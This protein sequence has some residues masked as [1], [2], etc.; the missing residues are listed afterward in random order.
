MALLYSLIHGKYGKLSQ[1]CA[2]PGSTV[3]DVV[4]AFGS[5]ICSQLQ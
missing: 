2:T 5:T 1:S 3:V 4:E